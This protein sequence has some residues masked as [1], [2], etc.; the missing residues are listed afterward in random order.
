VW[1]ELARID[2][3]ALPSPIKKLLGQLGQPSLF[4]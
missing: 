1:W 4:A 2:E 3:A